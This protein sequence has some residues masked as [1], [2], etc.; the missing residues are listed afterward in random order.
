VTTF[1]TG[2]VFRFNLAVNPKNIHLFISRDGEWMA[3]RITPFF[4]RQRQLALHGDKFAMPLQWQAKWRE[5]RGS[6]P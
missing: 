2:F 4:A 5:R 6:N 1:S 3:K